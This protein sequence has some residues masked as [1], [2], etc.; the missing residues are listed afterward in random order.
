MKIT[1]AVILCILFSPFL[2]GQSLTGR[3]V[4]DFNALTWLE[5]K[6]S[7]L[8]VSKP[9]RT[10]F[11][12]W[13]K[14][15]EQEYIG[16]GIVVQGNDTV[17]VEKLSIIIQD[18]EIHYVADVPENPEPVHFKFTSQSVHGFTCENPKHDFPKKI[19]YQVEGNTMT[20]QT[21]GDGKKQEFIFEKVTN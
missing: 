7:R 9:G 2:F 5:G 20:A 17:F 1:G 18:N 10:A 16:K 19:S 14:L 13:V 4:S 15:N 6:W 12:V 21:S 8:H 11:E 3:T